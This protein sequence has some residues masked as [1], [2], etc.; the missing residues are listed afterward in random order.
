[1]ERATRLGLGLA[2]AIFAL[3]AVLALTAPAVLFDPIGVALPR[4]EGAAEVRAA[5]F[6]LFG[7]AAVLFAAGARDPTLAP[8]ALRAVAVV[9]GGFVTGR[10]VSLALDGMPSPIGWATLGV[11]ATGLVLACA[12][13]ATGASRR[14]PSRPPR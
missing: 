1:M 2:A 14:R 10:L 3:V 11:E 4:P 5:Y 9:L 7:G 13:L 8:L 12:L 6:G